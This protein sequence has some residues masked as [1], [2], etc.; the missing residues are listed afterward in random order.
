MRNGAEIVA[1]VAVG[2][3][4]AF[5]AVV[6]VCAVVAIGATACVFSFCSGAF[7]SPLC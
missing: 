1:F 5:C 4:V 7:S 2:L 3:I 6:A